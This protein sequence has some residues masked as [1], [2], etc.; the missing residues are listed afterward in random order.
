L[1]NATELGWEVRLLCTHT[2]CGIPPLSENTFTEPG[3]V[4]AKCVP[5]PGMNARARP[6]PKLLFHNSDGA[7]RPRFSYSL[8]SVADAMSA[9]PEETSDCAIA[10]TG[11]MIGVELGMVKY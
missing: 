3:S 7:L 8:P 10:L 5:F 6:A 9:G 1:P 4:T 2:S 11:R